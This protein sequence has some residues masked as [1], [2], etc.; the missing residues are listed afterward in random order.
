[1]SDANA[2]LLTKVFGAGSI[3]DTP[4]AR[5]L[6]STR[7][8][9]RGQTMLAEASPEA[10][11]RRLAA[12]EA[13]KIFGFDILRK[14]VEDGQVALVRDRME[15]ATTLRKRREDLRFTP[16]RFARLVGLKAPD[17]ARVETPGAVSS[18]HL[19]DRLAPY[20]AIDE[21]YLGFEPS[22]SADAALGV[23]FRR[24]AHS[25]ER[26]KG[27][28][29]AAVG[30]LAESAWVI[31]RQASLA[32]DIG[33]SVSDLRRHFA[34]DPDYSFPTYAVGYR[35]AEKA[36]KILNL[37]PEE[38]IPNLRRLIEDELRIPLVETELGATLAGATIAI[39]DH[40]G[41]V[42]NIQ[43]R[44]ENVWVRRMTLAHELGHLLWDPV[45]KLESLMV[46]NY[47][48]VEGLPGR[49]LDPVEIRANA[50]AVAFLAP[51]GVVESMVRGARDAWDAITEIS[52]RFGISI[53][54]SR[55]HVQN[56]CHFQA[57]S[58]RGRFLPGPSEE[59]KACEDYTN[60]FFPLAETPVS[61]RGRFA[62]TVVRALEERVISLDTAATLLRTDAVTLDGRKADIR[63]ISGVNDGPP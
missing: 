19:L 56:L 50:F 11:G 40:R 2:A 60:D 59:W 53:T 4:E 38:P 25:E 5:A 22:L 46:D 31:A 55:A 61:R 9:V 3:G 63:N 26:P 45:Q 57:P 18:I 62:G 27:L 34:P 1:M 44:N 13:L 24:L 51:P 17:I 36:R 42:V 52:E 6:S 16:E 35:L 32:E 39:G 15:P 43:G 7:E 8:F 10:K 41:I 12:R 20:L 23:R 37:E 49:P 29:P 21:R 54:A 58:P 48:D 33:E 28:S 47:D 30:A 14:A